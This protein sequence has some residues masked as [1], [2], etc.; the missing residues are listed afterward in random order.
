M[1]PTVGWICTSSTRTAWTRPRCG[2]TSSGVP[3]SQL[4]HNVGGRFEPVDLGTS[5]AVRGNGCLATDL[6]GDGWTDLYITAD[7]PNKLLLNGG[8]LEFQEYARPAG[9]DTDGWSTAAA[10]GDVNGDGLIDLFVATYVDLEVTVDKPTGHF[11]Q[12]HPG[13]MDHLYLG[14]GEFANG[15]P[16]FRDVTVDIGLTR[17][18]RGLGAVL[19]DL[20]L[21]GDLDLYIAN[22]GN[23]NR[24]YLAEPAPTPE[25]F[26]F[27]DVTDAADVGD[28]GS[29]MGVASGD[30]DLDGLPDVMVTNWDAEL[31]ALYRGAGVQDGTPVFD[32]STFR[33]GLAGLGNNQTGWGTAWMDADHDSDVDLLVVN[34]HVPVSDLAEDAELIRLY[35]NQTMDGEPARFTDGSK[36]F[37]LDVVGPRM[38]RGSAVA[39]F[40]NDGD[41]DVAVNV[42]GGRATVLRNDIATGTWLTVEVERLVPGTDGRGDPRRWERAQ[43]GARGGVQ[44]SVNQLPAPPLRLG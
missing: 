32:Y 33:I 26:R 9:V 17:S 4:Y 24:L 42:I 8:G 41:L 25:G 1:T 37:G 6:D 12:D 31:H 10:A 34:G 43:A 11:P 40:D 3:R 23:Q 18:D 15:A 36:L 38:A 35:V 7:G 13:V 16:V 28:S 5:L 19:S 22:D 14:T 21:D 20:D 44:L 30:Y 29:G 27:V 2:S 39:D